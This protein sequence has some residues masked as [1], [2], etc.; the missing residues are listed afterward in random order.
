M[1]SFRDVARVLL[2][3]CVIG[4]SSTGCI[5]VGHHEDVPVPGPGT[6]SVAWTVKGSASPAACATAGA[7]SLAI[8]VYDLSGNRVTT[9]T[10]A[11]DAFVDF[12]DLDP[13]TY[14][15]DVTLLDDQNKSITT[16]I[17]VNTTITAD[18]ETDIDVDFPSSSFL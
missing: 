16:T 8:D 1:L 9:D 15:L 4:L 13:D 12:I 10:V 14:S 7:A 5:L 18:T 6:L 2:P 11:C 3:A 17:R